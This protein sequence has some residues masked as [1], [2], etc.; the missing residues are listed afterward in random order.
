MHGARTH[1]SQQGI[2]FYV[3]FRLL[4]TYMVSCP[5]P[6]IRDFLGAQ[7]VAM[8]EGVGRWR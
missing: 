1:L 5:M 8:V 3:V 7:A 4:L 6:L 2:L